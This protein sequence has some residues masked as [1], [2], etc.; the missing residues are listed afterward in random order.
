MEEKI[1]CVLE[2]KP[3]E[4]GELYKLL[5][6]EKEEKECGHSH[7]HSHPDGSREQET[8]DSHKRCIERLF[9]AVGIC[10][11]Q[12]IE[13]IENRGHGPVVLKTE[14]GKK[15]TLGR[16]QASSVFVKKIEK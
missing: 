4:K 5:A 8:S 16:G 14:D 1:V 2:L 7:R 11:G 6:P 13:V 9:E 15:I 12:V 10:E 3:G